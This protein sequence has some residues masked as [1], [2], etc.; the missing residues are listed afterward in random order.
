MKTQVEL[1]SDLE[2]ILDDLELIKLSIE[3]VIKDL[4]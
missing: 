4:K 2:F 1:I 3:T